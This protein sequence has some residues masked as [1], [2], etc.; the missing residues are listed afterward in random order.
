M[1]VVVGSRTAQTTLELVLFAGYPRKDI[2]GA[3]L[4]A[5]VDCLGSICL[6]V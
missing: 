5:L 4:W 1:S 6:S 2:F 3:C